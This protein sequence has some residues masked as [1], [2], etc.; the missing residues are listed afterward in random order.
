[1][2]PS[3]KN[4]RT[5]YQRI[6]EE[7]RTELLRRVID[8]GENIKKVVNDMNVNISTAKAIVKVY[9]EE[10]RVGKKKKRDKVINVIQTYSFYVVDGTSIEKL[11][12]TV[13]EE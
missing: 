7:I 12:P 2:R 10:G 6:T 11:S 1:M 5:T 13:I 3:E 4:K 9:Q 8:T